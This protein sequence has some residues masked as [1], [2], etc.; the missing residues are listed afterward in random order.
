MKFIFYKVC[1]VL[2]LSF[3][4][5]T[6]SKNLSKEN[7]NLIHIKNLSI[8]NKNKTNNYQNNINVMHKESQDNIPHQRYHRFKII[9]DKFAVQNLTFSIGKEVRNISSYLNL[10]ENNNYQK[11]HMQ[12]INKKGKSNT[13]KK[14]NIKNP[15]KNSVNIY[16][17]DNRIEP[18]AG[19]DKRSLFSNKNINLP[20]LINNSTVNNDSTLKNY[21]LNISSQSSDSDK[22]IQIL[23]DI[24][25]DYN[26]DSFNFSRF[27]QFVFKNKCSKTRCAYP[28]GQCLKGEQEKVCQC[29]KGYLNYK[30]PHKEINVCGYKQKFQLTAFF[31]ELLLLFAGNVY[32]GFYNYAFIKG[33]IYLTIFFIAYFKLPCRICGF[34]NSIKIRC[35]IFPWIEYTTLIIILFG[36]FSWQMVDLIKIITNENKD[37]NDMPILDYF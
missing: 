26:F 13:S 34:E 5:V 23:E 20:I 35:S 30:F 32:L 18:F 31:L 8:H 6:F 9:F 14:L 36:G 4:K 22:E 3:I 21:L 11:S 12:I 7:Y 19:H 24:Y 29:L 1:F 27:H 33:A 37:G 28:R 17:K 16:L 25:Y 10:R 2:L 15:E